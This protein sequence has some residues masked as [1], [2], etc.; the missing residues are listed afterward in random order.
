MDKITLGPMPYMSVLPTVIVGANVDGKANYMTAG[1][2]TIACIAPPMV[3]VALNKARYTVKGIGEN[4]TF[5]LNIPSARLAVETDY[6]GIVSGATEDKS[7]VF[8]S[9]YGTLKTAPMAEECPVNIECKLFKA[10]DCGS[11]LL[12]IG[13]VVEVYAD[14][15]CITDKKP[16]VAKINPILL[17]QSTYFDIGKQVEKAFSAGKKY[18][19][20]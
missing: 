9:F 19:K 18:R 15:G 12:H 10:I 20:K 14:K 16:D 5:S 7:G 1:A 4:K 13:E 11:H 17:S 2:A 3:C 6:C 8:G